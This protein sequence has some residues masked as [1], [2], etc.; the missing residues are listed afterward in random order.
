MIREDG[1]DSHGRRSAFAAPAKSFVVNVQESDREYA[2]RA[3]VVR[4]FIAPL[5]MTVDYD[6]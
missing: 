2:M 4:V 1:L 6:R 5:P 3:I